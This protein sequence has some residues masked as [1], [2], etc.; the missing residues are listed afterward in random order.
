MPTGS[1]GNSRL[2]RR[3]IYIDFSTVCFLAPACYTGR[4]VPGF[5]HRPGVLPHLPLSVRLRVRPSV[6]LSVCL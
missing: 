5:L 1:C 3:S 2:R 6:R 4:A